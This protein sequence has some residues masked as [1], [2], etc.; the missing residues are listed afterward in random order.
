MP[1][2]TVFPSPR[3][4]SSTKRTEAEL[5][6]WEARAERWRARAAS[7]E[8]VDDEQVMLHLCA[9]WYADELVRRLRADLAERR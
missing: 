8:V 6:R 3:V 1:K 4:S 9:A 5:T 7:D 2:S